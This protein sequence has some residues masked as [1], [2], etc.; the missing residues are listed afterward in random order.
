M[1]TR[2]ALAELAGIVFLALGIVIIAALVL[3]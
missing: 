1:N 2:R 3:P